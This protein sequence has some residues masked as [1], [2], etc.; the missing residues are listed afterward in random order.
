VRQLAV[1]IIAKAKKVLMAQ[2]EARRKSLEA[3]ELKSRDLCEIPLLLHSGNSSGGGGSGSSS[4][5][6]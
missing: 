3:R 2:R 5:N 1:S 6:I 4:S